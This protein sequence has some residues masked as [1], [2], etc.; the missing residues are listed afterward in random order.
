M[1]NVLANNIK[2]LCE[3]FGI[4]HN[5][6]AKRSGIYQPTISRTIAGKTIPR[7]AT[8]AAIAKVFDVDPWTLQTSP[9]DASNFTL[10][11]RPSPSTTP[12]D[13]A[14]NE[15][16]TLFDSYAKSLMMP[17]YLHVTPEAFARSASDKNDPATQSRIVTMDMPSDDLAP[18]VPRGALLYVRIGA[19]ES[20]LDASCPAVACVRID[21][22]KTALAFGSLSVSL[23]EVTLTTAR[24]ITMPVEEVMGY[25]VAWTVFKTQRFPL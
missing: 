8:I 24:G 25:V 3:R 6:L 5:E 9:I 15:T 20:G 17:R 4:S 16:M 18:T 11:P 22:S 7:Q 12:T 21:D 1:L 19:S 13:K 14:S 23:G 10:S 2:A